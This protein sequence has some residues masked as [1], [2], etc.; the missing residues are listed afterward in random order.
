[1]LKTFFLLFSL[2]CSVGAYAGCPKGQPEDGRYRYFCGIGTGG[3]KTQALERARQN[4]EIQAR[5]IFGD[6]GGFSYTKSNGERVS[7]A[8]SYSEKDSD[9]RA[10]ENIDENAECHNGICEAYAFFRFSKK[11][12]ALEMERLKSRKQNKRKILTGV[13]SAESGILNLTTLPVSNA[14]VYIDG[15]KISEGNSDIRTYVKKGVRKLTIDHPNYEL[16]ETKIKIAAGNADTPHSAVLK[17]ASV[18]VQLMVENVDVSAEIHV[19]GMLTG[20]TPDKVDLFIDRE[21]TVVLKHPEM[22]DYT[23]NFDPRDMKRGYHDVKR[24]RMQEKPAYVSISSKPE[25]AEVYLDGA[26]AGLTPLEKEV[27]RGTHQYRVSMDGFSVKS[28]KITA[29]GGKTKNEMVWLEKSD[30]GFE[31]IAPTASAEEK[32]E[33]TFYGALETTDKYHK[34]VFN[35]P[36]ETSPVFPRGANRE[37]RVAALMR[38]D[39]PDNIV[40]ALAS[41]K[42]SGRDTVIFVKIFLDDGLYRENVYPVMMDALKPLAESTG[43][44][45]VSFRCERKGKGA[46]RLT[47][48]C[49]IAKAPDNINLN[50]NIGRYDINNFLIKY[51]QTVGTF[52]NKIFVRRQIDDEPSVKVSAVDAKLVANPLFEYVKKEIKREIYVFVTLNNGRE[53]IR[54]IP[55]SIQKFYRENDLVQ[56]ADESFPK[57]VRTAFN[58]LITKRNRNNPGV[59]LFP[60]LENSLQAV[61]KQVTLKGVNAEEIRSVELTYKGAIE[62]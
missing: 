25:G 5:K 15:V 36:T 27:S 62:W 8:D 52:N 41:Y 12:I 14:D 39:Y 40:R 26:Y 32:K 33:K 30:A 3:T 4:G 54:V 20:R 22:Y 35:P 29:V 23:L 37:E 17:P 34:Y 51:D 56:K 18:R 42:A 50:W 19:N 53:F 48:K 21:N 49:D 9:I 60:R 55:F 46:D 1:M 58:Q 43:S 61:L 47:A 24:I 44:E 59:L 16:Y 31:K 2:F 7:A 6:I 57:K 11:E 13:S 10:L 38:W 28:A 45:K